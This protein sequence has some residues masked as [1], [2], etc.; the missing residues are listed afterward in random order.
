MMSDIFVAFITVYAVG[1]VIVAAVVAS[2][3]RRIRS[4]ELPTEL[5]F[6]SV[7]LCARNEEH[8][9]PRC[10]TRLSA[11]DYP[12]D[13]IEIILVDDE[14]SDR[15]YDLFR[16]QSY[17]DSR[18]RVFSTKNE[19][20]DLIGKQRPLSLGIRESRGEIILVVDADIAVQPEWAKAHVAAYTD[21]IGIVGGTTRVDPR[22]AG[23]FARLQASDLIVKISIA[24]G[25]AGLGF[26]LAV[27]GNNISFLRKAYD[28]TG[29]FERMKPRIVEDV[30]LMNG[31]IR[32]AG[33]RLG[34]TSGTGGVVESTPEGSTGIFI[35][36]RR[37]W[38]NEAW[39]ISLTGKTLIWMEIV[40]NAAFFVS[41]FL[42]PSTVAPLLAV[43]LFWIGGYWIVLAPNPG[44]K[45]RDYLY[46]P[47]MLLFQIY[48]AS[49]I[50]YRKIRGRATIVW[51]G[52]EYV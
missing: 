30:A 19:P 52:R 42:V 13:K 35:E 37:R 8:N 34:W 51:K 39:D 46:I 3:E 17:R 23:F 44:A 9:L 18:F 16:K 22:G 12:A 49:I 21:N 2:G 26:P 47:P 41:I 43:V 7:V 40:M 24:M 20:R 38:L 50:A 27:M 45:F 6:I 29:G 15:T 32:D 1:Y 36:Q 33:Y 5:P 10:F 14:S 4:R 31:I 11:L 25:A 48:Y 28:S